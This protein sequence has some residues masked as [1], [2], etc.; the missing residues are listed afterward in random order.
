MRLII[1]SHEDIAWNILTFGRDPV[2]S[3]A[4]TRARESAGG[5]DNPQG[6]ALLGYPDHVRGGVAVVFASLHVMPERRKLHEWETLIYATQA[7][8]HRLARL[9][10]DA[11]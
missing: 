9:Q 1:D 7:E 8:A 10:A 4:E 2:R 5:A 6:E 3:V 11:Y